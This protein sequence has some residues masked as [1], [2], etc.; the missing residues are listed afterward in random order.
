MALNFSMDKTVLEPYY[1][2]LSSSSSTNWVLYTSTATNEIKLQSSGS[3]GLE[4]LSEEF[5]DGRIQWA[6]ASVNV[7]GNK[8]SV[9]NGI[10]KY[11][12]VN[13]CG[14]GVPESRKGLFGSSSAKMGQILKGAHVVV[15]ARNEAD[16]TPEVIMKKVEAA[17]GAKYSFQ[18]Q[19][20]QTPPQQISK[21]IGSGYTPV[22]KVDIEEL[23]K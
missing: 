1:S 9:D 11:V 8:G 10:K 23:K 3:S 21:N 13:W 18:Q 7:N 2:I 14:D 17:S 19:Q 4:E 6:F 22:G 15:Q 5:H 16:V 12:L 20:Q